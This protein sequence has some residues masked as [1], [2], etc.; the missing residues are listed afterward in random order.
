[1]ATYKVSL[2]DPSNMASM[3][4]S[5]IQATAE[6]AA[7]RWAA[8]WRPW[9]RHM[10]GACRRTR[11]RNSGPAPAFSSIATSRARPEKCGRAA[12]KGPLAEFALKERSGKSSRVEHLS[13]SPFFR[14]PWRASPARAFPA[15]ICDLPLV[16]CRSNARSARRGR[17]RGLERQPRRAFIWR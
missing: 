13:R 9:S 15:A 17:A 12:L 11:R 16:E 1:M 4:R 5:A 2:N 10:A 3:Y 14:G 6:A 8:G 7:G